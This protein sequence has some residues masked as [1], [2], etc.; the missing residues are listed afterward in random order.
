MVAGNGL[1]VSSAWWHW[2]QDS[3]QKQVPR[4]DTHSINDPAILGLSGKPGFVTLLCPCG[5]A[6]S[7]STLQCDTATL[8]MA[9]HD[10]I[11]AS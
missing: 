7:L 9:M 2:W 10:D 1:L 5:Y 4:S 3:R 6:C 11:L 8:S